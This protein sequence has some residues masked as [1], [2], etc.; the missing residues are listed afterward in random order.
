MAAELAQLK[1]QEAARQAE[2]LQQQREALLAAQQAEEQR[3]RE[4]AAAAAAAKEL[5][6]EELRHAVV[7]MSQV[8]GCCG[9]LRG[10]WADMC[11]ALSGLGGA[12][13][14]CV[15]CLLPPWPALIW[16]PAQHMAC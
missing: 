8:G 5:S 4:A 13:A 15:V 12:K 6:R 3:E 10:C 16:H 9:G 11:A 14:A 1:A 7:S 2:R